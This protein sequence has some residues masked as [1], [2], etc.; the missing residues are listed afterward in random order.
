[1]RKIL[2]YLIAILMF[3]APSSV[4]ASET[5]GTKAA[6]LEKTA[7]E[8][9][10]AEKETAG[11][12]AV[13]TGEVK[14]ES[15]KAAEKKEE[16]KTAEVKLET[17]KAAEEKKEEKKEEVK[18][19]K[20]AE[21]YGD[22]A[23][24]ARSIN[25]RGRSETYPGQYDDHSKKALVKDFNLRNLYSEKLFF[26]LEGSDLGTNAYDS[27][28]KFDWR[29][30]LFLNLNKDGILYNGVS[31]SP[32]LTNN[33]STLR[34][35]DGIGLGAYIGPNVMVKYLYAKEG[36]SGTNRFGTVNQKTENYL[37]SA[38]TIR[39]RIPFRATYGR[40]DFSP[41]GTQGDFYRESRNYEAV[42]NEKNSP[43]FY[44]KSFSAETVNKF[45]GN[46]RYTD[47]GYL[48]A[49]AA[50]LNAGWKM[51]LS[52]Y[53]NGFDNFTASSR[54]FVY[55]STPGILRD[56]FNDGYKNNGIG[57]NFYY[58]GLKKAYLIVGLSKDRTERNF[59]GS[60]LSVLPST[61]ATNYRLRY[62]LKPTKD[63]TYGLSLR[64]TNRSGGSATNIQDPSRP[65]YPFF[66]SSGKRMNVALS[67]NQVINKN[68]SAGLTLSENK[69]TNDGMAAGGV[70]NNDTKQ[71]MFNALWTPARRVST[72]YSVSLSDS[73]LSLLSRYYLVG[74]LNTVS[75]SLS[76]RDVVQTFGGT[77]YARRDTDIN[78]DFTNT[79]SV[80]DGIVNALK[81][82]EF[83]TN[84]EWLRRLKSGDEVLV[85]G[86]NIKF[87]DRYFPVNDADTNILTLN[88][89]LKF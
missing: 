69:V 60:G 2:F 3:L 9:K 47:K 32:G 72:N 26:K 82:G 13:K 40:T 29:G 54:T 53:N 17:A 35:K 6:G 24:E 23:L 22:M 76:G 86:T 81:I 34:K 25:F 14:V 27:S 67:A 85:R 46:Q 8:V 1:M 78:L 45:N 55:A 38:E 33:Y 68:L 39:L 74:R 65:I 31:S 87:Y 19:E 62:T 28:A 50:K 59:F 21:V 64:Y 42:S 16:A 58:S 4:A 79:I 7:A 11:K 44:A 48:L 43:Y 75:N 20:K 71:L 61:D 80:S 5:P 83:T 89:K 52:G 73:D 77:Y 51:T 63:V 37:V 15:Q 88:Y 49:A 66:A 41:T 56:N 36:L 57:A 70:S 30:R 12:E 84:L 10:K 18:S